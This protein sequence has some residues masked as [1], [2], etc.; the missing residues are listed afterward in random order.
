MSI[1]VNI[2]GSE[3]AERSAR[4][5]GS[6]S[7]SQRLCVK[8]ATER[9]G[10]GGRDWSQPKVAGDAGGTMPLSIKINWAPPTKYCSRY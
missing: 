8:K 1:P 5:V 6:S 3:R 10:K 2:T 4:G 9:V 7:H